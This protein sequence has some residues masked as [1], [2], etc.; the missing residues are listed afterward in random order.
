MDRKRHELRSLI[1]GVAEHETLVSSAL[2]RVEPFT[3][4]HSLTDVRRLTVEAH[5]DGASVTVDAEGITR[6]ADALEG[7]ARDGDNQPARSS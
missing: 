4:G 7:V 6:V 1:A 3:F 5:H 2:L